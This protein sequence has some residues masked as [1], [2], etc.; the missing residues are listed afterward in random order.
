MTAE[1]EEFIANGFIRIE[2][3]FSPQWAEEARDIMWHDLGCDRHDR[4]TWT[5]PVIRLPGYGQEPFKRAVNTPILYEAF[6]ALVGKG[7]W[8]PR[9]GL[10]TFPVRFPSDT[11]PGDTGW[12]AEAS[13]Q[14]VDGTFRT[15][16]NSKGRALLLLFLF[17][18]VGVNDAPTRILVGSHLDVPQILGPYG[19]EGLDF[20]MLAQ[21]FPKTTL[22]RH[23]TLA[24]GTAGTVYLCHPFLIHSAQPHHGIEPRFI[25]QPP[26][27]GEII[28]HREAGDYSP[29]EIAMRKGL[30][31]AS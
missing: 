24:T 5:K 2:Q 26:L 13:F 4:S 8:V 18:D 20:I 11:D 10:G 9:D 16:V 6:D 19:E 30:G 7:R 15:N 17:S 14:G 1:Q 21:K 25:A 29:V 12:H 3:A 23:M 27:H 31:W 28:L 22:E